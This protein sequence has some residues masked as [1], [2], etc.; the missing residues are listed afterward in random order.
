VPGAA[1]LAE[2]GLTPEDFASDA[3]DGY[4][5]CERAFDL[6]CYMGAQWQQSVNCVTGLNYL[7]LFHK[8]D[9]MKLAP[10]DYEMLENDIRIMESAALKM[11]NKPA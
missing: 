2:L 10:D 5:D 9:R 3:I 4:P 7:V 8:M 6:F 1:E 11:I